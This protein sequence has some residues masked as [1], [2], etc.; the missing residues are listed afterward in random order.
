MEFKYKVTKFNLAEKLLTVVFEDGGWAEIR[1][2]EPFPASMQ[3][4]DKIVAEYT[5]SI[6]DMEAKLNTTADLSFIESAIDVERTGQRRR[7]NP[8]REIQY[9]LKDSPEVV[10]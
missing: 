8:I 5:A 6:D 10:L 1:L 2:V 4:V 9:I 3:D 7:I